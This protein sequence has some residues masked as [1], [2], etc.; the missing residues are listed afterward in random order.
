MACP[1]G[2]RYFLIRGKGASLLFEDFVH[3]KMS[4][5]KADGNATQPTFALNR[6][7]TGVFDNDVESP[8]GSPQDAV[9]K[10]PQVSSESDNPYLLF[11]TPSTFSLPVRVLRGWPRLLHSCPFPHICRV[12]APLTHLVRVSL[13]FYLFWLYHPTPPRLPDASPAC[14]TVPS[15]LAMRGI[16]CRLT[17]KKERTKGC[18]TKTMSEPCST[19]PSNPTHPSQTLSK[20][21]LTI[22]TIDKCNG[23]GL[24]RWQIWRQETRRQEKRLPTTV[25]QAWSLPPWQGIPRM[26]KYKPKDVGQWQTAHK[27]KKTFGSVKGVSV[28]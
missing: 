21:W 4:G 8:P 27:T 16:V 13:F 22:L 15:K 1:L 10:K 20:L 17:H 9:R 25:A 28:H 14:G 24:K 6:K 11:A 26:K 23:W 18:P 19:Q 12:C 7:I 2:R 5:N 3:Q